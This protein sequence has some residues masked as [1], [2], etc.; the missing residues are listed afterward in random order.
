MIALLE[1]TIELKGEKF[2]IINVSGIGYRVYANNETLQKL[3]QKGEKVKLWVHQHIWENGIELYGFIH[4]AQLEF[5]EL[6]IS[7]PGVGPKSALGVLGVASLDT[8]RRAIAAGDTSY[9]T[10]VSGIGRR[11]AQKI[12]F[13]L[14][15]KIAGIG[16]SVNAPELE[17]EANALEALVSLGYSRTEAREVLSGLPQDIQGVQ[18]R[19][20]EA[21]KRLG[22]KR[23]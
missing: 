3:P 23:R 9:L 21:L 22:E 17:E 15:E 12:V 14:K 10:R 7:I 1:G 6:L 13:E 4:F 20:R 19:I 5:F 16:V 11:T 8:L 2:L 18:E